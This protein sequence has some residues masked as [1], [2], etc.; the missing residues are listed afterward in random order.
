MIPM[1]SLACRGSRASP[2]E[3]EETICSPWRRQLA[4]VR[5]HVQA[6]NA[7]G[8]LCQEKYLGHTSSEPLVGRTAPVVSSR[9]AS[10]W[11]N[12]EGR[13]AWS[14]LP[15]HLH[16]PAASGIC[17]LLPSSG[18]C[19][20]ASLGLADPLQVLAAHSPCSQPGMSLGKLWIC[21]WEGH[22]YRAPL[23]LAHQWCTQCHGV[24]PTIYS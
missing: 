19:P 22:P 17:A 18:H 9:P 23:A 24:L 12:R 6:C 7:G 20:S 10:K 2:L 15:A 3:Q 5:Q 16:P 1:P 21:G 8:P 4:G 13:C 14:R 11:T